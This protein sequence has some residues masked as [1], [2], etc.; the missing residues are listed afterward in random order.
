MNVHFDHAMLFL[1]HVFDDFDCFVEFRFIRDKKVI[2]R[3]YRS[4]AG[5]DWDDII[6]KNKSGFNVYFGVGGRKSESGKADAVSLVPALWLDIDYIDENEMWK[7]TYQDDELPIPSYAINS[8]HGY[9]V[10][11]ILR[12]PFKID[13]LTDAARIRGYLH[14]LADRLHAD[15]CYDLA[16][17]M[18]LPE[19]VNW[20]N[21]DAP[22]Q[23]FIDL[24]HWEDGDIVRYPLSDFDKFY[25]ESRSDKP[26]PVSFSGKLLPPLDVNTLRVSDKIKALIR[27]STTEGGRSEAVYAVVKSL[28]RADYSPDEILTVIVNNPIGDRYND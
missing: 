17:V 18:R 20:K 26:E 23:S 1:K 15:R 24:D 27:E 16:R 28:Q 3:F 8:G 4:F 7:R 19:T 25:I 9:H 12:K 22:M 5:I 14:G 6:K 13:N 21:P 10:Y 2:Q 11:W